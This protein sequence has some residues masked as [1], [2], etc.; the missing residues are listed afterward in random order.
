[1]SDENRTIAWKPAVL[2][3]RLAAKALDIA[4][5]LVLLSPAV[6]LGVRTTFD[7]GNIGPFAL[8]TLLYP[9]AEVL[10][11]RTFQG[12]PGKRILRLRVV[13]ADGSIPGWSDSLHRQW[14]LLVLMTSQSLQV[15]SLLPSLPREFD[16]QALAQAVQDSPSGWAIVT[17]V[18]TALLFAS[19]LLV[20]F[21]RD[22]R[23]FQDLMAGT[24]V[25]Q[26]ASAP[27][28]V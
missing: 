11:V 21:R 27:L 5:F 7:A 15:A 8:A 19:G 2:W 13:R 6:D 26:P 25:V 16:L 4:L 23:S 12:T 22:R 14:I 3:R 1:V 17:D 10:L 28:R 18:A 24:I 20:L 9:L